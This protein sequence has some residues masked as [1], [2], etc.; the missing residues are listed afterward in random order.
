[1]NEGALRDAKPELA[2]LFCKPQQRLCLPEIRCSALSFSFTALSVS[3]IAY[4]QIARKIAFRFYGASYL[5]R[6]KVLRYNL[7]L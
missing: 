6:S 5:L 4:A 2:A 3:C 7:C 1:M